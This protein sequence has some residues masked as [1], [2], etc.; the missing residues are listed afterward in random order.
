M[1]IKHFAFLIAISAVLFACKKD[2]NKPNIIGKWQETKLRLYGTDSTGAL[3]YD[4]T[5]LAPFTAL[6]YIQFNKNDTCL[7]GSDHY[8]YPNKPG[9]TNQPQPLQAGIAVFTYTPVGS[10][11]V[12]LPQNLPNINSW[13]NVGDTVSNISA[14]TLLFRSVIRSIA[15]GYKIYQDAYYTR[16]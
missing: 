13:Y 6:D 7:V 16:K 15:P 10:K 5:Y 14:N 12:L 3:L 2:S 1:K 4:T 9:N 8:F 11:F